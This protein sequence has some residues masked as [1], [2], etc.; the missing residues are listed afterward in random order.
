M[1]PFL[2]SKKLV[3]INL[4][5]LEGSPIGK[6]AFGVVYKALRQKDPKHKSST[7]MYCA[8]KILNSAKITTKEDQKKFHQEV[9]CQ[10]SLKH[11]GILPL[12]GY[13]IPLMN[14]GDYTIITEYM[15]NGSLSGFIENVAHGM[16]PDNL[17]TIKAINIFGIAAA[18][19]YVHQKDIIHR[20][21]KTENIMLDE[22][23]YPKV[24]DFGLSKVFEEGTQHLIQ[25]TTSIGTPTHMAPELIDNPHYDNKIDV[26]A[27]SIILYEIMTYNKPWS[28]KKNLTQFNLI[29]YVQDGQRP[30]IHDRE[31]P[32]EYVT[33]IE[34]CWDHNPEKRPSFIRI[35]KGLLDNKDTY[36]DNPL[37]DRDELD[38]YMEDAIVGLDFSGV[39]AEIE[40][41]GEAE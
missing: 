6:G 4:F 20:D 34:R 16:S 24:A 9:G 1:F 33:L 38:L 22:N 32:D 23:F 7:E 30:T 2:F 19:A 8:V 3:D 37:I 41:E 35:V 5:K 39:E 29:K 10:S 28:D 12:V 15:P 14:K 36:F 25:Q 18:M 13:T 40:A 17:E 21:L 31:I 27:Y 11:I 26:F